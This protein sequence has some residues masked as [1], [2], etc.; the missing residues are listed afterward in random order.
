M[1]TSGGIMDHEEARRKHLGGKIL[2]FFFWTCVCYVQAFEINMIKW[3][4][5]MHTLPPSLSIGKEDEKG[6]K[7]AMDAAC[8]PF[9]LP[10]WKVIIFNW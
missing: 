4:K 2:G 5:Q 10:D 7:N 6:G 9:S 8:Y 3:S 1:T